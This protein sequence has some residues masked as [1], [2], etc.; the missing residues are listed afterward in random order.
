MRP[1]ISDAKSAELFGGSLAITRLSVSR[2]SRTT[3]GV[4]PGDTP[5][6][7]TCSG[8]LRPARARSASACSALPHQCPDMCMP[9][10]LLAGSGA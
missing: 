7:T 8:S 6:V 10:A 3:D 4:S 9:G 2:G 5:S 1:G